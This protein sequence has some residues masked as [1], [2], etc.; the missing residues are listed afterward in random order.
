MVWRNHEGGGRVYREIRYERRKPPCHPST[1]KR[2]S[3][4]T[5]CSTGE[6]S[7]VTSVQNTTRSTLPQIQQQSDGRTCPA[8][9]FYPPVEMRP[10]QSRLKIQIRT[11]VMSEDTVPMHCENTTAPGGKGYR[12]ITGGWIKDGTRNI[13]HYLVQRYARSF[14]S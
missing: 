11:W 4:P 10:T 6:G 3:T 7:N 13:G 8:K 2:W 1:W 14:H 12:V 9:Q 5:T